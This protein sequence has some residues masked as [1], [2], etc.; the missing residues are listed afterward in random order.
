LVT[1]RSLWAVT[2]LLAKGEPEKYERTAE[3]LHTSRR[4]SS[5]SHPEW[6]GCLAGLPAGPGLDQ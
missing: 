1:R 6:E 3:Q 4:L 2:L 5:I